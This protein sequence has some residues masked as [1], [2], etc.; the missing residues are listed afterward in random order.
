MT[1]NT[2]IIQGLYAAF[3]E[4]DLP[5]LLSHVAEDCDWSFTPTAPGAEAVPM[6]R[7]LRTRAEVGEVYFGGVAET[8][9]FHAFAPRAFFADGDD[10]LVVLDL[11]YTVRPTGTKVAMEE[12]HHFTLDGHGQIVRYRPFLDTAGLIAAYTQN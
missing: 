1:T 7:N 5:R 9:E 3:A 12:I 4:G 8:L 2:E 10:V 11:E 6:L